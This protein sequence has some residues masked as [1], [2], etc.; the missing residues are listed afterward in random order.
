MRCG[1][2]SPS[3]AGG[4]GMPRNI[5]TSPNT[6]SASAMATWS[7]LRAKSTAR[8]MATDVVP[9]PPLA[10]HTMTAG[11]RVRRGAA[12]APRRARDHS[13]DSS[14]ERATSVFAAV[15]HDVVDAVADGLLE[16]LDR[17][18]VDHGDDR[19]V[20]VR[21]GEGA[22]LLE[23][24]AQ[25]RSEDEHLGIEVGHRD[26]RVEQR[27]VLHGGG[28]VAER[29]HHAAAPHGVRI[30]HEHRGE[31]G[32]TAHRCPLVSVAAVAGR[33]QAEVQGCM[34]ARRRGRRTFNPMAACR[35][36]RPVVRRG[37][38]AWPATCSSSPMAAQISVATAMPSGSTPMPKK[39]CTRSS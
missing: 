17:G 26:E 20:R 15:A 4:A 12:A 2:V 6:G 23:L 21:P 32:R 31:T 14:A 28:I 38:Q 9:T 33:V 39:P 5:A 10:L 3:A 8:L 37:R 16:H 24:V 13:T 27:G 11:V 36:V 30:D 1:G 19:Q 29:R 18:V 22:D 35:A 34:V 25:A 7:W